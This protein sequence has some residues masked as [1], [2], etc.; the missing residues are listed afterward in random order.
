MNLLRLFRIKG[1]N[2]STNLYY[3]EA[4]KRHLATSLFM[5]WQ[6]FVQTTTSNIRQWWIRLLLNK[7]F[8]SMP[9]ITLH[10]S[11]MLYHVMVHL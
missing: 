6:N 4:T 5:F 10:V 1:R 8:P 11:F 2:P 7:Y 9:L 3:K